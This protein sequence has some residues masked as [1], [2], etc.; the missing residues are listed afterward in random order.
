MRKL[1]ALL[2]ILLLMPAALAEETVI[3]PDGWQ[4]TGYVPGGVTFLVPEDMQ[5]FM[6]YPAERAAGVLLVGGSMDYTVQ[7]RRFEPDVLTL[8]TLILS[9]MQRPEADVR[10]VM[11]GDARVLIYRNT[12]PTADSELC[13]A[14]ITGL[15]GCLYKVSVFTGFSEDCSETAPVWEISR[16]ITESLRQEDFSQFPI[17]Q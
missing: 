12:A 11:H 2:L 10:V 14:A 15:D 17:P 1:I 3:Q 7:L 4:Y 5:S 6:L 13:G 8:K 9:M 16:I